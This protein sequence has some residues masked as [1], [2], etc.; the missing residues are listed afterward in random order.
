MA[1]ATAPTA[2]ETELYEDD[3]EEDGPTDLARSG[4]LSRSRGSSRQGTSRGASSRGASEGKRPGSKSRI[5]RAIEENKDSADHVARKGGNAQEILAKI[6][7]VLRPSVQPVSEAKALLRGLALAQKGL[8]RQHAEI[9]Q[10]L[11]QKLV[12]SKHRMRSGLAEVQRER[13]AVMGKKDEL[14]QLADSVTA[15]V[16]HDF[17]TALERN[18]MLLRANSNTRGEVAGLGRA[19]EAEN[20][21]DVLRNLADR[22]KKRLQEINSRP[23][24]RI[25]F[26]AMGG[27]RVLGAAKFHERQERIRREKLMQ[28]QGM[29][30]APGGTVQTRALKKA[31]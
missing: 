7:P 12:A 23:S 25:S 11:H 29:G 26:A 6:N 13:R 30:P 22:T 4:R 28:G 14:E 16:T 17:Q 31:R 10:Q 15:S 3:Y 9:H 20:P 18:G 24:A 2:F 19:G 21:D 8:K 1:A 5:H 27:A